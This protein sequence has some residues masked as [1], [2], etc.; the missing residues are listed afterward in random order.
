MRNTASSH[1]K[2]ATLGTGTTLVVAIAVGLL[3]GTLFGLRDS[4][5]VILQTGGLNSLGEILRLGAYATVCYAL[6]AAAYM[7]AVGLA[8]TVLQRQGRFRS[9][10]RGLIATCG[11]LCAFPLTVMALSGTVTSY[12]NPK[13]I[14]FLAISAVAA[15]GVGAALWF[16]T[17]RIGDTTKLPALGLAVVG[18]LWVLCYWGLWLKKNPPASTPI[19]L[20]AG[21]A[22][23][24]LALGLAVGTYHV[25]HA[26]FLT[27]SG[28]ARWPAVRSAW[29]LAAVVGILVSSPFIV[30]GKEGPGLDD[31]A[32]KAVAP[33][34]LP[35]IL[36]IVMDAAR[37]DALSCY[38]NP[39]Q[40][41]PNIDRIAAEG[42]LYENAFAAAPWTLPSHASMFTGL[43]PSA[44]GTT[45]EY[46]WLDDRYVTI[47]E[48]LA[49]HGYR[50]L[51]Y[52][53]NGYVRRGTNL[54]QGF[55]H[56]EYHGRHRQPKS[57]LLLNEYRRALR[58][59]DQ[60]AASTTQ[61][62]IKAV[63]DAVS[64]QRPFFVFINYM[65]SHHPYG[66]TPSFARWL[67]Q[68]VT[69]Q[70]ALAVSQT[71]EPYITGERE[72]T[73]EDFDVLRAL[74]HGDITYLDD[75]IGTLV[76]H[77]RKLGVLDDTVVIITSDHGELFG[78][79][80]LMKHQWCV[81][82][83]LLRVPLIVRYPPAFDPGTRVTS[84]VRLVDLVPTILDIAGPSWPDG[85]P[86]AGLSLLE[87]P[88][89]VPVATA[90]HAFPVPWM[91]AFVD[92]YNR[93]DMSSLLRRLKSIQT[94]EW[95]YI[96]SSDGRDELY[97]LSTDPG[98]TVNL[99]GEHPE[100]ARE[101]QALLEARLK[102]AVGSSAPQLVRRPD[103][104]HSSFEEVSQ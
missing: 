1:G 53:N 102:Q 63:T 99:I 27:A 38:G 47:A 14:E 78:E 32:A 8:I 96:W 57:R 9:G 50:T 20:V 24:L 12:A 76:E 86:L 45:A 11:G 72:M 3:G 91:G 36:W 66:A 2:S 61:S 83:E 90:E 6:G 73:V 98:E 101:L 18:T 103:L 44:H 46:R 97:D 77:L 87:P 94:L 54:T 80:H 49:E 51:G 16:L 68:G 41:T 64:L 62:V 43:L 40:T 23:L 71:E 93:F 104:V 35:N 4:A 34:K 33:E 17:Q 89:R 21:G 95:K 70:Q 7:A 26:L 15:V 81:Y 52:S 55:S 10:L 75:R 37:A 25:S 65:E 74:Y 84:V 85:R 30:N 56:F 67:P 88:P 79:H 69:P 19:R 28:K 82:N 39:R 31:A 22:L 42:V 5:R 59:T 13:N 58:R 48:V 92:S 29:V 100:K 60:G